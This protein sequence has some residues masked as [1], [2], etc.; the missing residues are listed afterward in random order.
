MKKIMLTL[1]VLGFA[2]QAMAYDAEVGGELRTAD[3]NDVLSI[4]GSYFLM[5]LK[6]PQAHSEKLLF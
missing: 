3:F 4:F 1:A 6:T 5:V 2:G